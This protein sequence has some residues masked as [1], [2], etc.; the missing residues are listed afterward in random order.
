M[1][2][3]RQSA[4][5]TGDA[6]SVARAAP[7]RPQQPLARRAAARRA[8][9]PQAAAGCPHVGRL[10]VCRRARGRRS[11]H[12]CPGRLQQVRPAR[13]ARSAIA[14]RLAASAMHIRTCARL[15]CASRWPSRLARTSRRRARTQHV[16]LRAFP[17]ESRLIRRVLRLFRALLNRVAPSHAAADARASLP[18]SA[19]PE[20]RR[21]TE[22]LRAIVADTA[23]TGA[24]RRVVTPHCLR[25]FALRRVLRA[26]WSRWRADAARRRHEWRVV[27]PVL[28]HMLSAAV[29]AA[30]AADAARDPVRHT[31]AAGPTRGA[32]RR[33]PARRWG[34]HGR[35][36]RPSWWTVR[37]A[38]A[39]ETPKRSMRRLASL[40]ADLAFRCFS[41]RC[42]AGG[43]RGQPAVHHPAPMRGASLPQP[44]HRLSAL[45]VSLPDAAATS[46]AAAGAGQALRARAEAAPRA[47]EAADRDQHCAS[48]GGGGT[49]SSRRPRRARSSRRGRRARRARLGRLVRPRRGQPQRG[50][51]A[52][53]QQR[54]G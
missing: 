33:A 44:H 17:R 27:R 15:R 24:M 22:E 12:G 43:V 39:E 14:L 1:S 50:P 8:A 37:R 2:V 10:R 19:P 38:K 7:A 42:S 35:R 45:L 26:A 41:P 47:G 30:A 31:A 4:V 53:H 9:A 5:R 21:V 13:S 18:R 25:R 54:G 40:R 52:P 6:R 36:T 16:S 48:R 20:S 29:E 49:R 3:R 46:P 51:C 28:S 11:G 23:A 32:S 34:R